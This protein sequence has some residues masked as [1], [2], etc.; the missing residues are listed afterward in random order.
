MRGREAA[1]CLDQ[2]QVEWG[3]LPPRQRR[4]RPG[5]FRRNPAESMVPSRM[6][7]EVKDPERSR[8]VFPGWATNP[9]PPRPAPDFWGGGLGRARGL[10]RAAGRL[11]R[12]SAAARPA[13]R[14]LYRGL[15]RR[16]PGSAPSVG[17]SAVKF[18]VSSSRGR[19][20]AAP[21]FLARFRRPGAGSRRPRFSSV[22]PGC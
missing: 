10:G 7:P 20:A 18:A 16:G 3:G 12:G 2:G 22:Q 9:A 19:A 15:F 1:S 5:R 8:H 21:W 14:A 13:R 17:V 11:A 6:S 4:R